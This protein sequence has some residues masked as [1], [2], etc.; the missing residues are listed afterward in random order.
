MPKEST[1][2]WITSLIKSIEAEKGSEDTLK[3]VNIV[4]RRISARP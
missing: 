3:L 1:K 4:A 2:E